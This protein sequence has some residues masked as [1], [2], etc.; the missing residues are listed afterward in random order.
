MTK[1]EVDEQTKD[2]PCQVKFFP[3]PILLFRTGV[4][5]RANRAQQK[6][7]VGT[8]SEATRALGR[9]LARRRSLATPPQS[10]SRAATPAAAATPT[11][12]AP[13]TAAAPLAAAAAT[14]GTTAPSP[15]TTARRATT[16]DAR[17]EAK[18][19]RNA[20]LAWRAGYEN[21]LNEKLEQ[22][23]LNGQA[24]V[25]CGDCPKMLTAKMFKQHKMKQGCAHPDP[26]IN[27]AYWKHTPEL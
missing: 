23:R 4:K 26:R 18:K 2:V 17:D 9:S 20:W 27:L 6:T 16:R 5:R 7:R 19:R 13:P 12:A 1:E 25:E 14:P 8:R 24:K 21:T 3:S 22:A 15:P 11:V 10:P